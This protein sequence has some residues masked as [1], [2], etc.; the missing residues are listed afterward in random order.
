MKTISYILLCLSIVA[1][2]QSNSFSKIEKIDDAFFKGTV[3]V[4]KVEELNKYKLSIKDTS[5]K[6]IDKI[7]TPYTI[8]DLQVGDIN[9]DGKT[10]MCVGII[11][12]TPFDPV[13]KKRLFIF[14]IDRNYIRP[15][16]LGSRLAHGYEDFKIVK[17]AEN[18]NRIRTIEKKNKDLYCI[19]EYKWGSFG[20]VYKKECASNL[21]YSE[22]KKTL[23]NQY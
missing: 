16:W 10:D 18:K 9:D 17:D 14:Q 22:A 6:L 8:F 2:R 3:T 23:I 5:G 19:S 15:L 7:Y 1:C 11:K 12:P 20:M 13:L 21:R 4:E